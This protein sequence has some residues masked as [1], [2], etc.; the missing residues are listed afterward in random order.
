MPGKRAETVG[1]IAASVLGVALGLELVELAFRIRDGG[2]FPHLNCYVADPALGVRLEPGAHEDVAFGGNPTTHVR[3][4]AEGYRGADW[5]PKQEHETLVVGDSQVFGLGVEEDATFAA[6]L[7][8]AAPAIAP[9]RN[10]GVPTYGP[11]EFEAELRELVASRQPKTVVYVVNFVNDPFEVDRP[12]LER[13]VVWDG[14]AVR[15][16]TAPDRVASFPGRH[17]LFA[18]SHALFALRKYLYYHDGLRTIR[19]PSEGTAADLVRLEGDFEHERAAASARTA[20][21]FRAQETDVRA[22]WLAE[23]NAD[24]RVKQMVLARLKTGDSPWASYTTTGVYLAAGAVPGDIVVPQ[25]G[26]DGSPLAATA[27]YLRQG[28]ELRTKLESSY[29]EQLLADAANEDAKAGLA[30]LDRRDALEKKLAVAYRAPIELVRATQPIVAATL[31]A[32]AIAEAA[33]ARFVLLALPLDVQVSDAEWAKY[34]TEKVDTRATKV[35]VDDLVQAVRDAGASAID[36]T[37]ALAA[38]EPGAF[39]QSDPHLSPKGHAVIADLLAKELAQPFVA[40]P[41]GPVLSLPEGRSR[42]P[43]PDEWPKTGS[44]LVHGSSAAGCDT[45][46]IRE[47]FYVRCRAPKTGGAPTAVRVIRGGHGE[48]IAH[49]ADGVATLVA[50]IVRGDD[51]RA[52]FSWADRERDFVVHWPSEWVET[53]GEFDDA[54]APLDGPGE[55]PDP[56]L[57]ACATEARGGYGQLVGAPD[58]RCTATYGDDCARLLACAEGNPIAMPTCAPG[59]RNAGASLHC[60]ATCETGT[61]GVGTCETVEGAKLC[62]G[63]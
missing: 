13:H 55:A 2:A 38:A 48:A 51:F 52:R 50:P 23:V 63:P 7:G 34:G 36:P 49:A 16:E 14:W 21:R 30:A 3:I 27:L 54:T 5:G 56:K 12:N 25:L 44:L 17:A 32:K 53:E 4:N 29:R 39:L 20:E 11:V 59:E 45:R 1:R 33:G 61:C 9:V 8:A 22:T 57:Q 6:R 37:G 24:Q 43:H 62:V 40:R 46:R 35:L 41:S 58:P 31:R 60:F 26:E 28:A 47:W 19:T 10:A 18:H 42:P 15:R